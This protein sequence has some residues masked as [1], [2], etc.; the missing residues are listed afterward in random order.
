MIK[1]L[2]GWAGGMGAVGALTLGAVNQ[3]WGVQK[4]SK[5]PISIREQSVRGNSTGYTYLG[6]R[7]IIGGGIH[8]GK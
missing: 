5:K 2:L 4:P 8:S 1:S 6:R 3:G 7:G